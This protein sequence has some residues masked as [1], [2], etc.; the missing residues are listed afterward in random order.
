M[1]ACPLCVLPAKDSFEEIAIGARKKMSKR[2]NVLVTLLMI[3]ICYALA[4][5]VPNIGDII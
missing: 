5:S 4:I 1:C 3:G 2:L